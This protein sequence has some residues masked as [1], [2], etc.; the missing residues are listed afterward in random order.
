MEISVCYRVFSAQLRQN[1]PGTLCAVAG[2]KNSLVKTKRNQE[3]ACISYHKF[4]KETLIR[5]QWIHSCNREGKWNPRT[6][7]VCS[8]HFTNDS[9]KRSLQAELL[10]I[11]VKRRLKPTAVP[12]LHLTPLL[13]EMAQ[14]LQCHNARTKLRNRRKK[15]SKAVSYCLI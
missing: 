13:E 3:T 10:N 8:A 11:P 1:M 12:T 15:Q 2:C 5:Q 7:S 9:Y 6:S 14:N 4:P